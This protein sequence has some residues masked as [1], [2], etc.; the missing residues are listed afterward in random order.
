MRKSLPTP[1]R[2]FPFFAKLSAVLSACLITAATGL[3]NSD[4]F[5]IF[6]HH[7]ETSSA[8]IDYQV[9]EQFLEKLATTTG[10][11]TQ[12]YYSAMDERSAQLL[13]TYISELSKIDV[14]RLSRNEQLAYWLNLKNLL[15]VSAIV[16]ERPGR[17]FEKL[18]GDSQ[19]PGKL[20]QTNRIA[21]LDVPLSIHDI[22]HNIL[23][24]HFADPDL[25]YG[26]YQGARG[27]PSLPVEPFE[28]SR[29]ETQLRERGEQFV[30]SKR[31]VKARSQSVQLPEVYLWYLDSLFE[32]DTG[33]L[34]THIQSLAKSRLKDKLSGKSEVAP[35][36]FSYALDEAQ[37]RL[38]SY[39]SG[40]QDH[41]DNDYN[42]YQ[43]GS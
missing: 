19:N 26:M 24:R 1:N 23:L 14:T 31:S 38:P 33:R 20:W 37:L 22:E 6:K 4:P 30:N 27:G 32:G 8:R 12:L 41:G 28:G 34:L 25:I 3:A 15:V 36:R 43:G 42:S 17:S 39:S 13:R 11:R 2:P 35:L 29:V 10:G 5:E 7:D 40:V 9:Y 18:R 21:V 16:D